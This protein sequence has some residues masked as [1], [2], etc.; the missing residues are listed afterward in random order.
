MEEVTW[1]RDDT[2]H[3]NYPFLFE[4]ED[5]ILPK[6]WELLAGTWIIQASYT[7]KRSNGS[8]DNLQGTTGKALCFKGGD[9]ILTGC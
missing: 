6:K 3:A 5:R 7:R 4:E 8:S 2:I 1:E 9:T